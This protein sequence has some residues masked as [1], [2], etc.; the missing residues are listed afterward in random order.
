MVSPMKK[1]K[2]RKI[3]EEVNKVNAVLE[4]VQSLDIT[5]SND[6]LYAGAL[7]VTEKLGIITLFQKRIKEPWW[8]RRIERKIKELRKDSR[9]EVLKTVER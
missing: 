6:L 8:K 9:V 7:V 5:S 4:K 3:T 2:R 1:V